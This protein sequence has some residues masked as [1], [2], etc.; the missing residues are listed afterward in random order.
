M[1]RKYLFLLALGI[2][3]GFNGCKKSDYKTVTNF[4]DYMNIERA[5][6]AKPNPKQDSLLLGFQFG[7]TKIQILDQC[8]RLN[9]ED[10]LE[11]INYEKGFAIN[12]IKIKHIK[13]TFIFDLKEG[14][15][16]KM[17]IEYYIPSDDDTSKIILL[18]Y[19]S[20]FYGNPDLVYQEKKYEDFR[21]HWKTQ[22]Q[23]IDYSSVFT[24]LTKVI[25]EDP[26]NIT[27]IDWEK[28]RQETEERNASTVVENN[29][30]NGS[31]YQVKD[32]LKDNLNDPKSYESL[33]WSPVSKTDDGFMVRHKYRAKNVYGGLIIKEQV[34]YLNKQGVVINVVD[35]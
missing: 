25:I 11:L 7:M 22:K 5:L 32:Y 19:L 27:P 14:L 17:L 2:L 12:G 24:G 6:I 4:S 29:A 1:I 16:N 15:M 3:Y 8:K 28:I 18:N 23:N 26:N 34:F 21:A 33:S 20:N 13:P 31:V 9:I 35:F 30:F 10:S